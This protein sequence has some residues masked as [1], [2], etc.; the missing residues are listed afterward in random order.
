MQLAQHLA[1]L[2][3]EER[4]LVVFASTLAGRDAPRLLARA[5]RAARAPDLVRAAEAALLLAPRERLDRLGREAARLATARAPDI[6]SLHPTRR[7]RLVAMMGSARSL[8]PD[9]SAATASARPCVLAAA[10]SLLERFVAPSPWADEVALA[11]API[12]AFLRTSIAELGRAAQNLGPSALR[13]LLEASPPVVARWLQ[14]RLS[15]EWDDHLRDAVP[16]PLGPLLAALGAPSSEA[17][18]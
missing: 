7:V 3:R 11:P 13:A 12:R 10:T 5:S 15:E 16:A 4:A 9:G 8:L 14:M 17:S 2:S 18:S 6:A 1:A